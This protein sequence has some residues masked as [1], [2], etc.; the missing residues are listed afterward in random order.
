ARVLIAGGGNC[1]GGAGFASWDLW[2]SAVPTT[3]VVNPGTGA[4]KLA[5][6]RRSLTATVVGA[7]KVLLAGGHATSVTA[8]IFTLDSTTPASSTVGATAGTM[9]GARTGHSAT[10][11]TSATNACPSGS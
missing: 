8:D 9:T 10:L 4:N 1:A 7:G 5:V 6:A 2:D 11:P 3:P